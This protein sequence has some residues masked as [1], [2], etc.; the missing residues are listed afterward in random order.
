M[1]RWRCANSAKVIRNEKADGRPIGVTGLNNFLILSHGI[2]LHIGGVV[3]EVG[4]TFPS[5][6]IFDVVTFKSA[7]NDNIT[8]KEGR[9]VPSVRI[10]I[11]AIVYST[12]KTFRVN[13]ANE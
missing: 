2:N 5:D 8:T 6:H 13:S 4:C 10:N 7:E 3:V 12:E 1:L 9:I 11:D